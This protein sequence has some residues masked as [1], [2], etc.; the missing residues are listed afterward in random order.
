M[1]RRGR[2]IQSRGGQ[3]GAV[4]SESRITFDRCC[5]RPD[6]HLIVHRSSRV[7]H[8]CTGR[9]N[10]VAVW[11]G[12]GS[13]AGQGSHGDRAGVPGIGIKH[14]LKSGIRQGEIGCGE[15]TG[16]G[17]YASVGDTH[18]RGVTGGIDPTLQ[19]PGRGPRV[20]GHIDKGFPI[21]VMGT[22]IKGQSGPED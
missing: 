2:Q 21:G 16:E 19:R 6:G 20:A 4:P 8:A 3:D 13:R 12:P 11:E 9:H 22:R 5:G 1:I 14:D 17:R 10:E 15:G 18:P 7:H